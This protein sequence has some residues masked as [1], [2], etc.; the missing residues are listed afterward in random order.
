MG[1][2]EEGAS[3]TNQCVHSRD[4][5]PI[6]C[7]GSKSADLDTTGPTLARKLSVVPLLTREWL[8]HVE[9]RAHQAYQWNAIPTKRLP[10]VWPRGMPMYRF[11]EKALSTRHT[12]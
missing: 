10:H 12:F 11:C 4:S 3:D 9:A 5:V 8:D 6:C 2:E 1:G 7:T